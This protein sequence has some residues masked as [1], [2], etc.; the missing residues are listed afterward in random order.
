MKVTYQT[1]YLT[2]LSAP[3]D[4]IKEKEMLLGTFL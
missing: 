4:E 2:G 1:N 3:K